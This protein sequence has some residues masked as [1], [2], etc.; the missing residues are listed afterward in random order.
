MKETV[1]S[2]GSLFLLRKNTAKRRYGRFPAGPAQQHAYTRLPLLP[3][4]QGAEE[5]A[6]F[7]TYYLE[8]YMN[9]KTFFI[10]LLQG[11]LAVTLLVGAP[12]TATADHMDKRNPAVATPP[13]NNSISDTQPMSPMRNEKGSPDRVLERTDRDKAMITQVERVLQP[14]SGLSVDAE[15]GTVFIQGTVDTRAER[16]AIIERARS[17]NGVSDV[18]IDR[19]TVREAM[20]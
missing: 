4:E 16:N 11:A 12:L 13:M 15:Q 17:V 19:L 8:K 20:N 7:D 1:P 2:N 10:G 3:F 6:A 9:R 18:N 14:A 5:N